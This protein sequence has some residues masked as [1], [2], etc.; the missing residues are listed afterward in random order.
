[1][2]SIKRKAKAKKIPIVKRKPN[3]NNFK[4]NESLNDTCLPSKEAL[5]NKN[6]NIT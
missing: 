2:L 6:T 3:T 5:D 1:M 4:C